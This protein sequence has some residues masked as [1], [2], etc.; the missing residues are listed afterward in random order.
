MSDDA[1]DLIRNSANANALADGVLSGK[2]FLFYRIS[3]DRDPA[4][5]KVL[6][7]REETSG[8]DLNVADELISGIGAANVIGA[9]R[10]PYVTEVSLFISGDERFRNGTSARRF[11]RSWLVSFTSDPALVPPA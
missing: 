9:L 4:V 3:D 10:V 8:C 1:D 11:S 6:L 5:G 7:L 2:E